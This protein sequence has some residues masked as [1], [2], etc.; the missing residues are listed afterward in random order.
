MSGMKPNEKY[1]AWKNDT[2][3]KFISKNPERKSEF[4]TASFTPVK[5]LYTPRD[6]E[7]NYETNL[8][9][10]GEYPFTRGIQPTGQ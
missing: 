10:P 8:G 9:F 5:E 6:F 1:R 2:Y 3:T 7:A 4:T